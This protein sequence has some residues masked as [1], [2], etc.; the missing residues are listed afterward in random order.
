[1]P[2]KDFEPDPYPTQNPGDA[3]YPHRDS[4]LV[5]WLHPDMPFSENEYVIRHV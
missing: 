4:Y 5:L 1:M 2:I 3:A